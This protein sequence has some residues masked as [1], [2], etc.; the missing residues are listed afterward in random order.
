MEV[1]IESR[2]EV[3]G[4]QGGRGMIHARKTHRNCSLGLNPSNPDTEPLG[5]PMAAC[6]EKELR[7]SSLAIGNSLPEASVPG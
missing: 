1:R 2:S 4:P 5:H 3:F 6:S 7:S